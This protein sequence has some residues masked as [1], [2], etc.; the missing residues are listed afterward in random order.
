MLSTRIVGALVLALLAAGPAL[1]E[2]TASKG[3]QVFQ[4]NCA[5]CHVLTGPGFSGPALAGVYGRKAGTADFQYSDVM[6]KSGIVWDDANLH[7]FL[8]DPSKLVPGTAMYFNVT[9]PQQRDDVV[10]YLKSLSP[11]AK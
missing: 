2:G 6:K 8:T 7:A 5:G 11:G 4:D 1:G 3:Q 10:A 9:D